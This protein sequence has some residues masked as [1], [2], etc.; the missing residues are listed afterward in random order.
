MVHHVYKAFTMKCL[1][2]M[3]FRIFKPM[4]NS[5]YALPHFCLIVQ[6]EIKTGIDH[7]NDALVLSIEKYLNGIYGNIN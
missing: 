2:L 3:A 5:I 4:L 7:L 1:T 6:Y